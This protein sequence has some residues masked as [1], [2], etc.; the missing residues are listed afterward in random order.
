MAVSPSDG[1]PP[2]GAF[3]FAYGTYTPLQTYAIFGVM[4][5][6]LSTPKLLACPSDERI[7]HSNFVM[8]IIGNPPAA[9]LSSYS[10]CCSTDC[11]P[12]FFDNFKLSYF[13]GKDA[14]ENQPQMCLAGDRNIVGYGPGTTTLPAPIPNGGYGNGP[15][16][17]VS[18]GT[19]FNVGVVTP[20]WTP[21]KMHQNFGNVLLTDGS[22][23]QLSNSKLRDQFRNSGDTA[24]MPQISG[25]YG[26]LLLFP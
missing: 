4:S 16:L 21:G 6:E 18:M 17:A 20:A 15:G 7:A 26:N 14:T 12:A 10:T 23:Q 13:I 8:S 9:A 25:Q 19:N 11:V 1:G 2:T 3:S 24:G 22:V 5:N